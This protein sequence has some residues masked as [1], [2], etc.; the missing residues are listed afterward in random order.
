MDREAM[1]EIAKLRAQ[2]TDLRERVEYLYTHLNIAYISEM[3]GVDPRLIAA[4][5]KGNMVDAIRVY[6]EIT[7]VGLA[8][9][10]EAVEKLWGKYS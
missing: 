3:D 9:A 7:N 1:E 10:K 4:I 5:K 8:Q 2:I 6:S